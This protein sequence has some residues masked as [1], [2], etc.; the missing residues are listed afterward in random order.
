M[1]SSLALK[2]IN[3]KPKNFKIHTESISYVECNH[4]AYLPKSSNHFTNAPTLMRSFI[5]NPLNER[6]DNVLKIT[7]FELENFFQ[8]VC[9]GFYPRKVV[10]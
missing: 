3:K 10:Q 6:A 4:I 7:N 8:P 5:N 1:T 9:L 2:D